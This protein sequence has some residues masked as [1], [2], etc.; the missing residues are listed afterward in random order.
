MGGDLVTILTNDWW[1][2]ADVKDI[3]FPFS[4]VSISMHLKLGDKFHA[5][6]IVFGYEIKLGHD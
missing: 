2:M 6:S 1:V 5:L 4:L 3:D